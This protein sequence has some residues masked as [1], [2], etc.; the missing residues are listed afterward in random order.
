MQLPDTLRPWRAWL[1]WMQPEQW[2]LF[3]NWM[4]RLEA[5]LGPMRS[6]RQSGLPE[7]DG[8]SDLQRRGAYERLLSSEWLLAEE[9]PEEFLRR[10]VAGE[11]LFLAPQRR[12][13]NGCR[14][15]VALFDA[16]PLQWGAARLVQ[17]ALLILLARRAR[18][19]GAEFA[20]GILQQAPELF[21]LDGQTRLRQMLHARTQ[22]LVEASHL[23][24]WREFLAGQS[25][26]AGECWLVAPYLPAT[27][28]VSC[29]HHVLIQRRLDGQGLSVDLHAGTRKRVILPMPDEPRALSLLRGQFSNDRTASAPVD[30]HVAGVTLAR[31]PV[32]AS[33]GKQI[34]LQLLDGS[35]MVTVKLPGDSQKTPPVV[36]RMPWKAGFSPVAMLFVGR[37][38]GAVLSNGSELRFWGL[39]GL[40]PVPHPRRDLLQLPP[41]TGSYV[42]TA[43]LRK[44]S[45]GRLFMLD[46]HG[47]LAFWAIDTGSQA[48]EPAV[49]VTHLLADDVIGM[50]KVNDDEVAYAR[51]SGNRIQARTVGAGG[52]VSPVRLI[53]EPGVQ[54]H[55]VLFAAAPHW[56]DMGACALLSEQEKGQRWTVIAGLACSRPPQQI[57]L[58]Q[59]WKAIGLLQD[60]AGNRP[61]LL[62]LSANRRSVVACGTGEVQVL[63]TTTEAMVKLSFC[64]ISGTVAALTD[65]RELLVFSVPKR[66]LCL[67]ALCSDLSEK[68]EESAD[69]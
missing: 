56:Q 18:E 38:L 49:G 50:A 62:A 20:W 19:A 41:A 10:A 67:Q 47:H 1:E 27:G 31:P 40:M 48:A 9:F 22:A 53:G 43:L 37:T 57:M 11:H 54:Y 65:A 32:I 15:L 3:A 55:R 42:P 63:F 61:T 69:V 21:D 52:V 2:P 59:G 45:E 35:G 26:E 8:L 44:R 28:R 60:E 64:P 14:R 16:G 25:S 13:R 24:Q 51:R 39:N 29:S 36:R 46:T 33:S 66:T 23:E 34:A 6:L 4:G 12:A 5:M 30:A 68:A 58:D 17:M 7:P